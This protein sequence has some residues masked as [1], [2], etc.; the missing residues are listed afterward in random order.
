MLPAKSTSSRR[1]IDILFSVEFM[2][3]ADIVRS[4]SD[5]SRPAIEKM[6]KKE[7]ENGNIVQRNG[8]A[9]SAEARKECVIEKMNVAT[10]AREFKPL[11]PSRYLSARLVRPDSDWSRDVYPSVNAR[12]GG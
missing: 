1:L 5:I 2:T 8:L 6:I 3:V 12:L 4:M 11:D 7:R 10:T 9:L